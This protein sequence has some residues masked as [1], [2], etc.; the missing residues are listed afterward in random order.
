MR[1]ADLY[2]PLK[3]YLEAQ[4]YEVK[5]EIGD[6]DIMARR[7]DEPAI[8]VE[9]KLT[10]SLQLVMQG[11]VRQGLFDH[12][13]LAVPVSKGWKLRYRDIIALC[14]RLSLGLLAVGPKGVEAHLDPAPYAPRL[15]A[16][17]AARLLREF[18]RR[19]GDPNEGG[20]TGVK[21]MTAYRQDALRCALHLQAGPCKASEVAKAAGVSRAA[22]QMRH[23]HYGWFERVERGIYQLT[24][25]GQAALLEHAEMAEVLAK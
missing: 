2:A 5:A 1:E 6:C 25:K 22:Q 10:F 17:P 16:K 13:Y 18:D 23:D 20:I 11:V 12:V 7:G 4:G 21:K 3:A 15:K 9:M 24:P 14:R 19:V 8:I